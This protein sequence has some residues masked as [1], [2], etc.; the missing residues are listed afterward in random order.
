MKKL[1]YL[2]LVLGLFACSSDSADEDNEQNNNNNQESFREF[3]NSNVFIREGLSNEDN[4]EYPYENFIQFNL[5]DGLGSSWCET[6]LSTSPNLNGS[7]DE[8]WNEYISQT[9]YCEFYIY[10]ESADAIFIETPICSTQTNIRHSISRDGDNIT[11][12]QL[13]FTNETTYSLSSFDYLN[14]Q[15]NNWNNQYSYNSNST[16]DCY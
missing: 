13:G 3:L 9:I 16:G 14:E 2:F 4:I 12:I 10:Q 1:L 11:I 5:I 7:S 15:K 8:P 6:L